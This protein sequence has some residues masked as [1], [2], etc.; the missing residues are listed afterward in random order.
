MKYDLYGYELEYSEGIEV[1]NTI[2]LNID[3]Y[4]RKMSANFKKDYYE[5]FYG[6]ESALNGLERFIRKYL[7]EAVDWGI[8]YLNNN[9]V[10]TYTADRF[11]NE[12]GKRILSFPLIIVDEMQEHYNAIIEEQ[13]AAMEYRAERKDSRGRW[14]GGGFGIDGAIQGAVTAGAA[15]MA[16]G[17]AHSAANTIGNIGSSISASN[18]KKKLFKDEEIMDSLI[19]GIELSYTLI[20]DYIASIINNESDYIYV[21]RPLY[22]GDS[23]KSQKSIIKNIDNGYINDNDTILNECAKILRDNPYNEDAYVYF[24]IICKDPQNTIEEMSNYFG[25]DIITQVKKSQLKKTLE[26]LNYFDRKNFKAEL[27][28]VGN[29][30]YDYGID[31]EPIEECFLKIESIFDIKARKIDDCMYDTEDIAIKINEQLETIIDRIQNTSGNDVETINAIITE[32]EQSDILSKAKYI[33]YLNNVLCEEDIRFK[34]VTEQKYETRELAAQARQDAQALSDAFNNQPIESEEQYNELV[35][36][37]ESIKTDDL[38][39]LYTNYLAICKE[40]IEEQKTY[41]GHFVDFNN[42]PRLEIAEFFYKRLNMFV[43][44]ELVNV[45]FP[46]YLTWFNIISTRYKTVKD[47]CYEHALDSDSAFLKAVE[48]SRSYLRYYNEKNSSTKSLFGSIKSGVTGVVYKNYEADFNFITDCGTRLIPSYS[49]NDYDSF[50][51]IAEAEQA[52]LDAFKEIINNDY[53]R[54]HLPY[55]IEEASMDAS[56][57]FIPTPEITSDEITDIM[58]KCCPGFKLA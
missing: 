45:Q 29:I 15:N 55:E 37:V 38:K 13:E 6:I 1:Y 43:K 22:D 23:L 50:K 20:C 9:D 2:K 58:K 19:Y 26:G 16:S 34:M 4:S 35:A 17:L 49:K 5:E 7:N 27:E 24:L 36:L 40:M 39:E 52:E 48:H 42:T 44:S 18:K 46:D 51:N 41:T 54:V 21:E 57:L 3:E 28:K 12:Y 14:E 10:H 30:I 53:R 47:K 33:D 11:W 31:S 25:I 56:E 32:L 8:K